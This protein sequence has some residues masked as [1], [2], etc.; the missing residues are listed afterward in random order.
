M[1]VDQRNIVTKKSSLSVHEENL[2][3]IESDVTVDPRYNATEKSE[4]NTDQLFVT[5]DSQTDLN[6]MSVEEIMKELNCLREKKK[7][8]RASFMNTRKKPNF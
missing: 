3:T 2:A 6:L 1:K 8:L 4:T 5:T 7:E